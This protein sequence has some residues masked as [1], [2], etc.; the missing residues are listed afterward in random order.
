M[1]EV[2]LQIEIHKLFYTLH[3]RTP[4]ATGT[5]LV[6]SQSS[7]SRCSLGVLSA[8]QTAGPPS[9]AEES[10]HRRNTPRLFLLPLTPPSYKCYYCCY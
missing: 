9:A 10:C 6:S 8:V 3:S 1:V 4:P 7:L 2:D 5:C